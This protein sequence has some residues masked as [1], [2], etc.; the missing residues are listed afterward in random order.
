[1][2]H[3]HGRTITRGYIKLDFSPAWELNAK[4]IDFIFFQHWQRASK[5]IGA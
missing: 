3:S 5:G 4:V 1:M 2:N